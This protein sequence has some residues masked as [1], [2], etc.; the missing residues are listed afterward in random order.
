MQSQN[1]WKLAYP[2]SY[3]LGLADVSYMVYLISPCVSEIRTIRYVWKGGGGGKWI[4]QPR[5]L[6]K[7]ITLYITAGDTNDENCDEN[8]EGDDNN[9]MDDVYMIVGDRRP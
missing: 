1:L 5:G 9:E 4:K 3:Q 6:V 8:H 2:H 7:K